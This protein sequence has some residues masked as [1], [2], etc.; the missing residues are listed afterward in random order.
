MVVLVN[1][2]SGVLTSLLTVPKLEPIVNTLQ[3][4]VEREDLG[5]GGV[6]I[7]IDSMVTKE[8]LVNKS[9]LVLFYYFEVQFKFVLI[10][11]KCLNRMLLQVIKKSLGTNFDKTLLFGLRIV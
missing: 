4:L 8:L 2:Y 9:N 6:T 10:D 11:D 7:E 5:F 3:E 1:A